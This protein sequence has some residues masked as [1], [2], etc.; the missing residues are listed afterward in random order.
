M[1]L[2][3]VLKANNM[4]AHTEVTLVKFK[5]KTSQKKSKFFLLLPLVLQAVIQ[6]FHHCLMQKAVVKKEMSPSNITV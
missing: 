1:H 4:I 2:S 3:F 5:E 6:A